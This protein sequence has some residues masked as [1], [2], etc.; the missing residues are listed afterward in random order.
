[1]NSCSKW[2]NR[3]KVP[4]RPM[5]WHKRHETRKRYVHIPQGSVG[6][7]KE[8]E[9]KSE[10]EF[11]KNI[12][13]CMT[14]EQFGRLGWLLVWWAH[15]ILMKHRHNFNEIFA[16]RHVLE[17]ERFSKLRTTLLLTKNLMRNCT[18]HHEDSVINASKCYSQMIHA[19]P[20]ILHLYYDLIFGSHLISETGSSNSTFYC[21]AVI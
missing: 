14:H 12:M 20:R 18:I 16:S 9:A 13:N 1:M 8:L 3:C 5:C 6:L 10:T 4:F 15:A 7:Y 21:L 19:K 11:F 17:D 2:L